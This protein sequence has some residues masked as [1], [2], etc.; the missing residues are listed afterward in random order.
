M[1]VLG[2]DLYL[3]QRPNVSQRV[4]ITLQH[5]G[6]LIPQ[7]CNIHIDRANK[8]EVEPRMGV[9]LEESMSVRPDILGRPELSMRS[10]VS[11]FDIG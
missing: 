8:C 11:K 4:Q 7:V 1:R 2:H 3:G 6:V 10:V 5:I 9:F